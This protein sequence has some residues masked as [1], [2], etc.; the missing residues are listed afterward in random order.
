MFSYVV[1][2][3]E[4]LMVEMLYLRKPKSHTCTALEAES[5]LS[6]VHRQY[7][8]TMRIDVGDKDSGSLLDHINELLD[9]WPSS[10]TLPVNLI[11]EERLKE[12]L[13]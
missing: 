7:F 6:F 11:K 1:S 3:L 5:P 8:D 13:A 9:A 10:L 2:L 12:L 4:T